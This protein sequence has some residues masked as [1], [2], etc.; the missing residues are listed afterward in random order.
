MHFSEPRPY[1]HWYS[2]VPPG[3]AVV[4]NGYRWHW[5]SDKMNARRPVAN[6]KI[7]VSIV[8]GWHS[9]FFCWYFNYNRRRRPRRWTSPSASSSTQQQAYQPTCCMQQQHSGDYLSLDVRWWRRSKQ[10]ALNATTS[11]LQYWDVGAGATLIVLVF[12]SCLSRFHIFT[13]VAPSFDT[14]R[15]I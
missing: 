6:R 3:L 15:R 12:F 8:I 4:W 1:L 13:N 7:V 10:L 5:L 9:K 11:G 2:T 14:Y